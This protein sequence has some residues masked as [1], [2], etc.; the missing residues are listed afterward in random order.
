MQ[1]PTV[2]MLSIAIATGLVGILFLFFPGRIRQLEARLNAPWGDR[3]IASLR[4][5]LRGEEGVEQVMNRD[6]RGAQLVWDG[7]LHRRPRLVGAGLGLLAVWLGS[8]L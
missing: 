2:L 4:L 5:G 1:L 8:Q 6:I 3:E 7:W